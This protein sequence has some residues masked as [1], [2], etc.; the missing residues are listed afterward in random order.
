LIPCR[1]FFLLRVKK[2]GVSRTEQVSI[3][4]EITLI[5]RR[6]GDGHRRANGTEKQKNIFPS[7][8]GMVFRGSVQPLWAV[9]PWAQ[10]AATAAA[11]FQQPRIESESA[12]VS[13]TGQARPNKVEWSR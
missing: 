8:N 5:A 13:Q 12:K 10:P 6:S 2:R 9:F 11:G 3:T 4:D 7:G 1:N